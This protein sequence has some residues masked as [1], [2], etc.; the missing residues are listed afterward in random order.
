MREPA[1]ST[2]EGV[3]AFCRD[4]GGGEDGLHVSGHV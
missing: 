4:G 1:A 3:D 2:A